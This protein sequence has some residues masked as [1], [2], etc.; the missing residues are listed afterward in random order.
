[1]KKM[2]HNFALGF[3]CVLALVSF[4]YISLS[5]F[6]D[7]GVLSPFVAATTQT[8]TATTQPRTTEKATTTKPATTKPTTTEPEETTAATTA[9]PVI[10]F[11]GFSVIDYFPLSLA[12]GGSWDIKHCQGMAIDKQGG[13]AYYSYTNTFVKCDLEGNALGTLTGFEG[14]LG[15]VCYNEK[16]GKVYASLNPVGKKA[17]YVAIIDVAKL[18]KKCLDCEKSGLV[19]TVHLPE[20][21]KDFSA[22]VQN[23]GRTYSRRYGVSGTDAMCFGPSFSSGKGHYLTISCG[24]TPQTE[25]TDNDYQ[26][27]LQYDVSGWWDKY[28]QPLNESKVHHKGPE[29]HAGKYFVYTGNTNYGVQ[30]M[31]YFPELNLW[32]LNV[33]TTLKEDKFPDYNLFI[34]DGDIKPKKQALKGQQGEDVQKVLTLYQDGLRHENTGIYGWFAS[35][36]AKGIEYVDKGLFYIIHPYKTWYG[37]QTGVAYLYVWDGTAPDPFTIAAGVKDDYVI[38]KK[39]S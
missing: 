13:F 39:G 2:L 5:V 8:T 21:W 7:G 29:K 24:T 18:D 38:S 32:M 28:A 37:K 20:V 11:E 33:Y 31:T 16:D 23:G 12:N 35:N 4:C 10:E 22:K 34:V 25:R 27:L 26:I 15:D 19:R 30:T 14:H 36:G 17:L 9:A 3:I 6:G 1:M